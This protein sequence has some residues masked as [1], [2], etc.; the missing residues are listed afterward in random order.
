MDNLNKS[1]FGKKNKK[2]NKRKNKSSTWND[3]L[4]IAITIKL[5]HI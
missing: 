2:Q 4:Q 3:I 1:Q 5:K